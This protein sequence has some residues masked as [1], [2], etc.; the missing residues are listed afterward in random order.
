MLKHQTSLVCMGNLFFIHGQHRNLSRA[1]FGP[2]IAFWAALGVERWEDFDP[3]SS[4]VFCFSGPVKHW[5]T[6]QF[7]SSFLDFW[8][9]RLQITQL[10]GHTSPAIR[11]R[12]FWPMRTRPIRYWPLTLLT[13]AQAKSTSSLSRSGKVSGQRH[14]RSLYRQSPELHQR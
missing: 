13:W 6:N 10:V 5:N 12:L 8:W 14:P 9:F 7:F 11:E 3:E 4:F 1:K 2:L